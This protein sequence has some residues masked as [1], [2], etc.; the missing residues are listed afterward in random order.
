MSKITED[1]VRAFLHGRKFKRGNMEVRVGSDF[2]IGGIGDVFNGVALYQHGNQIAGY[3][4]SRPIR[5]TLTI[6]NCGWW[7]VTTKERLSEILRWFG[8]GLYSERGEWVLWTRQHGEH[9]P[10]HGSARIADLI[11]IDETIERERRERAERGER[12]AA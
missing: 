7:S 5:E 10:F 8:W 6:S 9:K 4:A 12:E 1:S 3:D 2:F 11:E